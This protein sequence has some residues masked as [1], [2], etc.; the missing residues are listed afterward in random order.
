MLFD[1]G[2]SPDGL[3]ENMRR[4][5]VS[6]HDVE[7][8]VLSHG[9]FDHTTGMDGLIRTLGSQR[10]RSH[11]SRVL[12]PPPTR[13]ARPRAADAADDQSQRARRHGL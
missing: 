11:P 3:I 1:T 5:E 6:P 9:H 4:L 12:E 10:P 2:I 13:F 7:V 8:I